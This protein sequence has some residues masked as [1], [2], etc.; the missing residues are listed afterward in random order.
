[1]VLVVDL[2][3]DVDVDV[4]VD[5]GLGLDLDLDVDAEVARSDWMVVA[6]WCKRGAFSDPRYGIAGQMRGIRRAIAAVM[7]RT[8]RA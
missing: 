4:D 2:D 3:V 7:T 6:W 5:L 1:M 8:T